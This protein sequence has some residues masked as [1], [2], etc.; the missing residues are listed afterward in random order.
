MR[1]GRAL[2]HRDPVAKQD[3]FVDRMGDEHH[4][5]RSSGVA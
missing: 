5:L 1:P 3:R 4:G 2:N